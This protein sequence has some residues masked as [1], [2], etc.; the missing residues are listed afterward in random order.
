MSQNMKIKLLV[1]V[2]DKSCWTIPIEL[3][4]FGCPVRASINS[5]KQVVQHLLLFQTNQSTIWLKS[6]AQY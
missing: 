1:L 5:F 2:V 3:Y 6:S 4:S